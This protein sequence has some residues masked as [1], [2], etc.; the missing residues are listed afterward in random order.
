[1]YKIVVA[2][3]L[4]GCTWPSRTKASSDEVVPPSPIVI[5][6]GH[7]PIAS[8]GDIVLGTKSE[9]RETKLKIGV[10]DEADLIEM[11]F[12]LVTEV[13]K[14]ILAMKG[15]FPVQ[16][17][18][19]VTEFSKADSTARN[20]ADECSL[21]LN[22]PYLVTHLGDGKLELENSHGAALLPEQRAFLVRHFFDQEGSL[23]TPLMR[24]LPEQITAGETQ[25]LSADQL[26]ILGHAAESKVDSGELVVVVGKSPEIVNATVTLATRK[27]MLG[28]S[29]YWDLILRWEIEIE[30]SSRNIQST[31]IAVEGKAGGSKDGRAV[32]G[33]MKMRATAKR[34]ARLN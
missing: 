32:S 24:I 7:E 31:V 16:Y 9:E 26:A 14:E 2:L 34:A 4:V 20:E 10:G 8:V 27:P 22:V 18:M 6:F 15:A 30:A 23:P 21:C 5:S 33:E 28:G 13:K 25:I 17:Q 11:K 1:M 3:F 12:H 19:T 29:A